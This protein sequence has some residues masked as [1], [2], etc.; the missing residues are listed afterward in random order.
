MIASCERRIESARAAV[1][2]A[3]DGVVTSRMTDLEREWRMLSRPDPDAGLMDLWARIA[4][5]AWIDRKLWRDADHAARLDAAVALAADPDGVQ[6]AESAIGSLRFALAAWGA[7]IGARVRWRP[8][9]RDAPIVTELLA[10]PRR[11]ASQAV[12][13][14]EFGPVALERAL[15]LERDIHEAA[16]ARFP[17]R[18]G[19]A[20][21]LAHAAFVDFVWRAAS[22]RDMPN[23]TSPLV[24]LWSAGYVL[25]AF[26]TSGAT[27]EIPPL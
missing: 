2:A 6:A 16:C 18:P 24:E 11:V 5:P 19:L 15:D 3:D 13:A 25:S 7:P 17:E 27:L 21:D 4:P 12:S 22:F 9:E 26:D 10:A 20:R 1:F 23:P 8:F 14:R